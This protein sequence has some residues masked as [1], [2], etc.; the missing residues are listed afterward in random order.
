MNK[1]FLYYQH[2]NPSRK[3]RWMVR[4]SFFNYKPISGWFVSQE[5]AIKWRDRWENET[6]LS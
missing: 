6:S 2:R 5:S 1:V 4:D 3:F